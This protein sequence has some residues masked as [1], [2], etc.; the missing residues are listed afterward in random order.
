M[1]VLLVRH[2]YLP[3][4][5]L[6]TLYVGSLKLATLEEP[7]SPNPF[8]PGGQRREG[9]KRESCVPDGTYELQ[10]HHTVKHPECWA[11]V[12]PSLGIWHHSVPPGL[13]YGRFAIL[14]HA[15]NTTL[16]IE[17]CLLV[18]LRHGRIEGTAAV[19]E[20]RA[21]LAQLRARLGTSSHSLEIRPCAGTSENKHD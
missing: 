21:A 14:I 17:G 15:G 13:P 12:N 7:W 16:D 10:P 18:G 2:A 4:V 6:G 1:N 20:S 9:L 5:T 3:D 19:L 8:G 11:L